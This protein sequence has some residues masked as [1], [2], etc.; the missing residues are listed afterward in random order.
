MRV[1]LTREENLAMARRYP[2]LTAFGW[3]SYDWQLAEIVELADDAS[4]LERWETLARDDMDMLRFV[5]AR[6]RWR[7]Q[8]SDAV[9][10]FG[11]WLE[12][13]GKAFM[14]A[15]RNIVDAFEE[16]RQ[17]PVSTYNRSPR[18]GHQFVGRY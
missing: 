2:S 10:R 18:Q 3:A 14:P 4:T 11:D 13:V 12:E 17:V 1:E 5:L 7:Y 6:Q 16:L 15:I 8:V 9:A